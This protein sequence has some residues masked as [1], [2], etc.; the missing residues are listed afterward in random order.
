MLQDFDNSETE[1]V[2]T[3]I[4][5]CVEIVSSVVG[6]GLDKAVSGVRLAVCNS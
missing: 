5:E 6:L 4:N 1:A 3:A 2:Q